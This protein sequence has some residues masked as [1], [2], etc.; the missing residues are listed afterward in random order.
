MFALWDPDDMCYEM[1]EPIFISTTKM[2]DSST[3]LSVEALLKSK[4]TIQSYN[5]PLSENILHGG[6]LGVYVVAHCDQSPWTVQVNS[7]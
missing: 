3:G 6:L 5:I 7:S 1:Q 2:L 4:W